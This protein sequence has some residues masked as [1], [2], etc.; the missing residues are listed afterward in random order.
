MVVEHGAR[1]LDPHYIG[2]SDRTEQT[3][4]VFHKY[5]SKRHV[6]SSCVEFCL[7]NCSNGG[8]VRAEKEEMKDILQSLK[9]VR[10]GACETMISA[11]KL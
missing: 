4:T 11:T 2:Y 10:R 1:R 6:W 9:A 8:A 7:L 5:R 3:H